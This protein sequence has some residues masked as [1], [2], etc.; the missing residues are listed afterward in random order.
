[1]ECLDNALD[2]FQPLESF[3]W[4]AW[5]NFSNEFVVAGDGM[6]SS[7][8]FI[9]SSHLRITEVFFHW[10]FFFFF[11]FFLSCLALTTSSPTVRRQISFNFFCYLKIANSRF[12][13]NTAMS[14]TSRFCL[15][16]I[17]HL[18]ITFVRLEKKPFF[19]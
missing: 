6:S 3:P 2:V 17:S 16:N 18:L 11:F 10:F 12:S 9:Y 13:F 19:V 14:F 8:Q 1:M 5:K 4:F 15:S 7:N